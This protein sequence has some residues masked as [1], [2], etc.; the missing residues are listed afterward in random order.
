MMPFRFQHFLDY[1][2]AFSYF[3]FFSLM[4]LLIFV[5]STVLCSFFAFVL[6]LSTLVIY[7]SS[8]CL[9]RLF[10]AYFCVFSFYFS[11]TLILCL[12]FSASSLHF[13]LIFHSYFSS[14]VLRWWLL[15]F[16]F[17]SVINPEHRFSCV[18]SL[19]FCPFGS[20]VFYPRC[21]S[22]FRRV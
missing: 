3:Y 1:F 10:F 14:F 17:H 22:L 15:T 16:H 20:G 12:L 4:P 13:R 6:C 9:L 7:F 5:S 11:S 8:P 18:L 19:T 2:S 21:P